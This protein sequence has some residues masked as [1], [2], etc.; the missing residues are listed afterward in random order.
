MLLLVDGT[1]LGVVVAAEEA[2]EGV[3]LSEVGV[4]PI[5]ERMSRDPELTVVVEGD[6]AMATVVVE[7]VVTLRTNEDA[8]V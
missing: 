4:F 5:N 1:L 6:A 7:V 8:F 2:E 3:A